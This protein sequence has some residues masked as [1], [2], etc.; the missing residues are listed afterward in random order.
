M[1]NS[2]AQQ[3]QL[4]NNEWKFEKMEI[5]N[6]TIYQPEQAADVNIEF[7]YISNQENSGDIFFGNLI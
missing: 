3:D 6:Q 1:I 5:N 2:H 4:I 7:Q